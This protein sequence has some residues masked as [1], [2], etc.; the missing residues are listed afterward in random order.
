[1]SICIFSITSVLAENSIDKCWKLDKVLE[2]VSVTVRV[3][4]GKVTVFNQLSDINFP[5]FTTVCSVLFINS[6]LSTSSE[7]SGNI[8]RSLKRGF[9]ECIQKEVMNS[10]V[11]FVTK[12]KT[13]TRIIG[14]HFQRIRTRIIV[15]Q[16]TK[17][18]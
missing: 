9:Y 14:R 12:I 2:R 18:K 11:I 15:I 13:R 4:F 10:S 6:S 3:I 8:T 17:T 16:K 5:F 7:R 1:M